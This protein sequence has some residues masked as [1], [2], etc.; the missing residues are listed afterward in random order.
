MRYVRHPAGSYMRGE[1]CGTDSAP[2][3]GAP[4]PTCSSIS[5]GGTWRSLM[6]RS[7]R[8][9]PFLRDRAC[10]FAVRNVHLSA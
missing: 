4:M 9:S 5:A 1:P 8:N 7:P 10:E 3:P 2:L 6:K